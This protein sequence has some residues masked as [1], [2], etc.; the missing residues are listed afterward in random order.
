MTDMTMGAAAAPDALRPGDQPAALPVPL[1]ARIDTE[2]ALPLGEVVRALANVPA[3]A[4]CDGALSYSAQWSLKLPAGLALPKDARLSEAAGSDARA[5]LIRI[6]RFALSGTPE[7]VLRDY[8]A[9]AGQAGL[10]ATTSGNT[11]T[12]IRKADGTAFLVTAAISK[13]GTRVDLI[14]RAR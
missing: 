11:L 9:R 10:V 2:G 12:A 7:A 6:V 4:G 8:G 14:T 5:C 1:D 13:D 3:F